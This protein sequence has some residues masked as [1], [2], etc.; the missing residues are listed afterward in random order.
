[1]RLLDRYL[2]AE[3]LKIFILAI[4]V[5]LM[6]LL[7]EKA[8]FLSNLLLSK[9]A[10]FAAIG[11]TLLYIAPSF[12]ILAAPLAALM[13]SLMVFSRMSADNEITAMRAGGISLYR[14]LMPVVMISAIAIAS[15]LYL[16]LY[17]VHE[18]NIAF[19]R[20][21]I[22]I[23]RSSLNLKIKERQFYTQ[24][25]NLLIHVHEKKGDTLIGVFISD[26]RSRDR[27]RIIEAK[28]GQMTEEPGK[29]AIRLDLIDGVIHTLGEEGA[30][31]TI[32]FKAY[33][34]RI[35]FGD[36]MPAAFEKE[37][38][39]LSPA[40]LVERIAKI[41]TRISHGENLKPP[42]AE[43]VA[44]YQKF[45]APLGCL[46][47]GL[48]GA[49]LG[50]IANRRGASGGFGLGVLMI[51]INYMLWT[52]GQNLGS[53]GKIPPLLAVWTP[54]IVMGAI[55]LYLIVRASKDTMPTRTGLWFSDQLRRLKNRVSVRQRQVG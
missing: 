11:K 12:L 27:K 45:S 3:Q 25:D 44:F 26:Q 21:T 51:I 31:Q 19:Q 54:N 29:D 8:N 36:A 49:P 46:A 35:G 15:T 18:S 6:T 53:Q 17:V 55:G 7:L 10:S 41:E 48:L 14:L 2:I 47:L 22:D 4:F 23:L 43:K 39:H 38:P 34:L 37:V 1:M 40:E 24:F 32:A 28:R 50:L 30:Y 52:V 16:S 20:A 5:L 13:S 33:T 9:G 42:Y